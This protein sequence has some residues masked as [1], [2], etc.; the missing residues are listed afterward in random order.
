LPE[1]P[2]GWPFMPS[3]AKPSRAASGSG[4][5]ALPVSGRKALAALP[6]SKAC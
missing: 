2:A 5:A 3:Q 6:Y 1:R 4:F